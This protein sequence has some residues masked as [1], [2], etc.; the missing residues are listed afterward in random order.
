MLTTQTIA[1]DATPRNRWAKE[2]DAD[3]RLALD[4]LGLKGMSR[5]IR[6]DKR[7]GHY[8][9]FIGRLKLLSAL[10]RIA[11]EHGPIAAGMIADEIQAEVDA[12]REPTTREAVAMAKFAVSRLAKPGAGT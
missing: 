10:G 6:P 1:T 8:K 11:T 7:R 12:G 5:R 4:V 3:G 2:P 9:W